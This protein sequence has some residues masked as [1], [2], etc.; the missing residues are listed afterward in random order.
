VRTLLHL[1]TPVRPKRWISENIQWKDKN[2]LNDASLQA[3]ATGLHAGIPSMCFFV[4]A[5]KGLLAASHFASKIK[6]RCFLTLSY[7][8]G[9]LISN[10]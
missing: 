7:Q 1:C 2:W 10:Q 8:N 9:G 4:E 5:G 6:Q 3:H